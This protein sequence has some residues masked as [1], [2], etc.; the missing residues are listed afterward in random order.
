LNNLQVD[1]VFGLKS[2]NN[3][4]ET[5]RSVLNHMKNGYSLNFGVSIFH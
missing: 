3:E 2:N 4:N 1:N 5:G